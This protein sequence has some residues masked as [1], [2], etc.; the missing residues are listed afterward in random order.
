MSRPALDTNTGACRVR[1]ARCRLKWVRL[2]AA[3]NFDIN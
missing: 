3:L 1:P 2:S